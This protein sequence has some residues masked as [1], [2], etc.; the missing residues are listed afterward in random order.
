MEKGRNCSPQEQFLLL[1]TIFCYLM[2]DFY[3]KTRIRFS[4]RDKRLFEITK[5]EITRVDCTFF[6]PPHAMNAED[7]D[8]LFMFVS[9]FICL[10]F[11]LPGPN[12]SS[13][14]T[15]SAL[16]YWPRE[17]FPTINGIPL[18]AAFHHWSPINRPGMTKIL[19]ERCDTVRLS[20]CILCNIM[21]L[22]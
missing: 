16:T 14:I 7:R 3:V 10:Y 5:V 13:Q 11:L 20:A 22:Y 15:S 6:M 2:L 4:L 8:F 1:S 12:Q 19:L 9:L 17:I 21:S 18:H